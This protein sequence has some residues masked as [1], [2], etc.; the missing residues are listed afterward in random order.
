[1]R[2]PLVQLLLVPRRVAIR[3][4]CTAN[5]NKQPQSSYDAFASQ[6]PRDFGSRE[7]T[8]AIRFSGESQKCENNICER[9]NS[10]AQ[11]AS[12]QKK[13]SSTAFLQQAFP[14]KITSELSAFMSYHMSELCRPFPDHMSFEMPI[15]VTITDSSRTS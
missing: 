8:N 6:F 11:F 13:T 14:E 15:L 3:V 9:T 7:S 2:K 5:H 1:M 4:H 12:K 10:E